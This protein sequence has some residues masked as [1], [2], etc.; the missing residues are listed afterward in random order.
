MP[1]PVLQLHGEADGAAGGEHL[2]TLEQVVAHQL[3]D[4]VAALPLGLDHL[5]LGLGGG[6]PLVLRVAH[7]FYYSLQCKV[8]TLVFCTEDEAYC[9][10]V[11]VLV[12]QFSETMNYRI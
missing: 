8:Q 4:L 6:S 10:R 1:A 3:G 7:C 5:H 9:F 2:V 12:C 11:K